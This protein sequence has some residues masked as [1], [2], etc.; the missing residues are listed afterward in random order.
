MVTDM[1]VGFKDAAKLFGISIITFCAVLVC[2]MFLNYNMDITAVK[3]QITP[4]PMTVFYDAMVSTA[5]IVSIVSGGCLLITS[6]VMLCFYIKHYIDTHKKELGILK[7]LGYSNL[8]IAANFCVFGISVFFGAALGF[9]G[10][11]VIMP[12]FYETQN[13]DNILPDI[14]VQFHVTLLLCMV[15]LPTAAFSLLS[16]AYACLKLKQPVLGLL[17][18]IGRAHV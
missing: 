2:T 8:K 4:G 14:S 7:A 10:A 5:K 11:F 17:K 12:L 18:E 3:D 9:C 16:M 13:A 15:I 6:A 1:V